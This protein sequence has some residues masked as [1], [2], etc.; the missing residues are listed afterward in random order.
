VHGSNPG[1][2]FE[3]RAYW[4]TETDIRGSSAKKGPRGPPMRDFNEAS[5]GAIRAANR[6]FPL[7]TAK[8]RR[9]Y[10]RRVTSR[11]RVTVR[12]NHYE[13]LSVAFLRLD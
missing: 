5:A 11:S 13:A 10:R 1:I 3:K 8:V 4:K 6:A 2:A 12:K 9:G 7:Q